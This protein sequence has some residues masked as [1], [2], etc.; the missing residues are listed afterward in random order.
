MPEHTPGASAPGYVSLGNLGAKIA[1]AVL[2]EAGWSYRRIARELGV[3]NAT[4]LR[5]LVPEK[6][7]QYNANVRASG[8][9]REYRREKR[10]TDPEWRDQRNAE[11]RDYHHTV[12]W[13]RR[14]EQ[15]ITTNTQLLE[16]LNA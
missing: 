15:R 14:I 4:P 12:R 16:Q 9:K 7:E 13:R 11:A 10:A 8:S 6:R 3:S 1:A 5:W 2:R